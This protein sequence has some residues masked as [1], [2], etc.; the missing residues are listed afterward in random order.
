MRWP[1][2]LTVG[3]LILKLG[4]AAGMHCVEAA[5]LRSRAP[6]PHPIPELQCCT[7]AE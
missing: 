6:H 4:K 7:R 3:T 2:D 1:V 5:V